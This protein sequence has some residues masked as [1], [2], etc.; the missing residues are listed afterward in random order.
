MSMQ[1]TSWMAVG[2]AGCWFSAAQAVTVL[3]GAGGALFGETVAMDPN[4]AGAVLN[5]NLLPF[6]FDFPGLPFAFVGGDVQ[7]RAVRSNLLG[8]MIFSPRIRDLINITF[9]DGF[10]IRSF[11]LTGY[12]GWQT[13][14]DYLVG[15][16]GDKGPDNVFRSADGDTLEFQFSDPLFI[17][18]LVGGIRDESLFPTIL[19]DAPS[20]VNEGRMT[21]YG[22]AT[23]GVLR[24]VSIG[25]L[26]VPAVPEPASA[27]LMGGALAGLL[28]RRRRA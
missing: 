21:I 3:P 6:G 26:A 8:T 22:T 24:S 15:A 7:N 5:D 19:T 1:K 10:E 25:G 28:V 18:G 4:Q 17:A 2:V 13:D 14:I 12:A 20:F 11:E 23:D 16:T 27:L 9:V